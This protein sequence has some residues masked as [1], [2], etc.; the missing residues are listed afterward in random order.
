MQNPD[1]D[2]EI[3]E[4]FR[5]FFISDHIL[6]GSA[7][8]SIIYYK[9]SKPSSVLGLLNSFVQPDHAWNPTN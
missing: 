3:E 7:A 8:G 4:C 9:L 1:A 6:G 5:L 2:L